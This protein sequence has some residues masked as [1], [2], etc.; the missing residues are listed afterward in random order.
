MVG[1]VI[2]TR[3]SGARA[4]HNEGLEPT[5]PSPGKMAMFFR[6][7]AG[8]M[9]PTFAGGNS[10]AQPGVSGPHVQKEAAPSSGDKTSL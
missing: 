6:S 2:V 10:R 3:L 4:R 7:V 9:L 8:Y 1:H 5:N